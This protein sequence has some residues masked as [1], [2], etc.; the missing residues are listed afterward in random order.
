MKG[1]ILIIDDEEP[2]RMFL[3][4]VFERDGFD[5][6]LAANGR[7]GLAL[8]LGGGFDVIVTDMVMPDLVGAEMIARLRTGGADTPLVAITG[9][10]DGDA[11]L[12]SIKDFCVDCVVFKPFIAREIVAAVEQAIQ[13]RLLK[14]MSGRC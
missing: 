1:R 2:I 5:V 13:T 11:N 9:Y 12:A 7:E 3:S 8:A 6:A 4:D 10:S 14:P